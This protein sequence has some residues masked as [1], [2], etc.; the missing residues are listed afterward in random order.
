MGRKPIHP[1]VSILGPF[2]WEIHQKRLPSS[3]NLIRWVQPRS[4]EGNDS[5]NPKVPASELSTGSWHWHI[6]GRAALS[7]E[8][9]NQAHRTE[10]AAN[11]TRETAVLAHLRRA[12]STEDTAAGTVVS[13]K[14]AQ[15]IPS[16]H[17]RSDALLSTA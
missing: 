3:Q 1:A 11:T 17:P 10:K 4:H 15:A 13:L 7:K 8:H 12:S 14:S 6:K 16:C 9:R 5:S 2:P